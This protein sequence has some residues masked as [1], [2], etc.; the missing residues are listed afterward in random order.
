MKIFEVAIIGAGPAGIMATITAGKEGK[1]VL[2]LE[3]NEDIGRKILATGNGRCNLT[4]KNITIDRYHGSNK[5]FIQKVL[6][7][8]DQ[9]KTIDFFENQGVLLKEEDRGR[10]FPRTNQA[11]TI[12][13][14]LRH[15]LDKE[16]ITVKTGEEV[17]DI[18][19]DLDW[20]IKTNLN[21]FVAKKLIL[22]TG[23]KAAHFLGSTGDGLFWARRLGHSIEPAFASLAPIETVESWPKEAQGIKADVRATGLHGGEVLAQVER[24]IIFT[25]YGVSGPGAMHLAGHLAPFA[26]NGD[27]KIEIDFYP[28]SAENEL[29]AILAK[30][31]EANAKKTV[32]NALLGILPAGL[33]P[34]ILKNAG[35]NEN[36]KAAELS[37]EK[38]KRI[39]KE[40]KQTSLKVK[41]IRPLKE[42]QVTKGGVSLS[43]VNPKTLKSLITPGLYF[44]GEILDV[45]ADSGGFNLQWAWSSGFLAGKTAAS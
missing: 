39:I 40:L 30:I 35:V 21:T 10:I 8:F 24:E 16:N 36:Q 18:T 34:I 1:S 37:K 32:K 33:L 22:T 20:K 5:D 44:A 4:N 14:A 7:S 11:V 2:L 45:N 25:H 31:L 43:D 9:N 28:E 13:E 41:K 38:R 6:S 3:K 19:K 17:K 12:V 23:G 42:A 29:D 26:E 27:A 15:A